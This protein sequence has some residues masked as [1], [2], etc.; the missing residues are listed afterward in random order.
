MVEA[1]RR[2]L[3]VTLLVTSAHCASATAQRAQQAIPSESLSEGGGASA[4]VER[5][6]LRETPTMS[7]TTP[8]VEAPFD[9]RRVH[10]QA[11][12]QATGGARRVLETSRAMIEREE[13]VRG[14][15]FTWVNAV[16]RRAGGRFTTEFRG[17]R[18]GRYAPLDLLQPGDWIHFINQRYGNVTHSAIF[19]AWMDRANGVALT[20]SY[21][22]ERRIEPGRY[23]DY[24][25]SRVYRIDRMRE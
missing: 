3:A 24:D 5:A 2:T 8:T 10:E 17:D 22:G 7:A 4:L 20:V 18:R 11:E 21:P 13:V 14:T 25:L 15:C 9:V 12:L 16:F 6:A 19:I 1:R 23:R